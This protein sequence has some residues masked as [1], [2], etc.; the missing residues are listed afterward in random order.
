M[1]RKLLVFASGT[2]EGGGSGFENLVSAAAVGTLEANIV[3]VVSD[4]ENGGVRERAERLGI[5]FIYFA[6]P[7]SAERYRQ[8]VKDTGAEFV[9]LSGWLRLVKG[10][11][12]KITFN[13]HPGPLP[14]F[15]GK[16]LYGKHVHEAVLKAFT[17]GRARTSAVSMHFVTEEFD[18]GPVFFSHPV[19]IFPDDTPET[20]G[21]RVKEAERLWQP[22]LTDRVVKGEIA[23]DGKDPETLV[24]AVYVS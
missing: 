14:T 17:E 12:S 20:L 24:G 4:I 19:P 2:K 21:K 1:K 15:G 7:Y 5:P 10:L 11:D 16:G 3:A 13:I 23:W 8:V 9:A 6:A 18:E 22:I